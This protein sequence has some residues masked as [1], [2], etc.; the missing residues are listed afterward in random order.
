MSSGLA[1]LLGNKGHSIL[2]EQKLQKLAKV[3][4]ACLAVVLVELRFSQKT[5]VLIVLM[6]RPMSLCRIGVVDLASTSQGRGTK[7][8]HSPSRCPNGQPRGLIVF[9]C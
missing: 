8:A 1:H 2:P 5:N 9:I 7:E 6:N 4:M 3:I